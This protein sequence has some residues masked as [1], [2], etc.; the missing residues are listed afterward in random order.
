MVCV[1]FKYPIP[2][3]SKTKNF[4][5]MPN[6]VTENTTKQISPTFHNLTIRYKDSAKYNFLFIS[7]SR[8]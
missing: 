4:D 8:S 5:I 2:L 7:P 6:P 1:S 3:R